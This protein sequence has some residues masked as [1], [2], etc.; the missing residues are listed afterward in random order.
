MI[1]KQDIDALPTKL[2]NEIYEHF[3]KCAEVAENNRRECADRFV[4]TTNETDRATA[5]VA[6]G[7]AVAFNVICELFK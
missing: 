1:K 6:Q 3:K 2:R 5:L 7:E 4:I